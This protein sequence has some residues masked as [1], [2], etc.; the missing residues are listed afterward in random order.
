MPRLSGGI[1]RGG[2]GEEKEAAMQGSKGRWS[3]CFSPLNRSY[4]GLSFETEDPVSC[5][6][7]EQAL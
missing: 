1:A 4:D 5:L 3:E 2:G 7:R 6:Q